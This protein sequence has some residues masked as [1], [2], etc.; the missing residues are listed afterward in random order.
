MTRRQ[1]HEHDQAVRDQPDDA[2]RPDRAQAGRHAGAGLDHDDLPHVGQAEHHQAHAQGHDQRVD[3]EDADADAAH[4]PDQGG[5]GE[6]DEQRHPDPLAAHERRDDEAGHRRDGADR[7]VDAAGQHRQGLAAGEDGERHG[8]P[9]RRA[10]PVGGDDA[11][12]GELAGDDQQDAAGRGA[13]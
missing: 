1:R 11:R 13:G 8:G 2:L 3:A 6:G 12:P 4:Q 9:Q 7:E 5:D 10:H